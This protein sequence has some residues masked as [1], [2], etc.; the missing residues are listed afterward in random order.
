MDFVL[1]D[2][3]DNVIGNAVS[4]RDTRTDGIPEIVGKIIP[5]VE[6]YRRTGINIQP[7]NTI[8]QLMALRKIIQEMLR[9]AKTMLM[10]PDYFSFCSL[11]LRK[12]NT[13]LCLNNRTFLKVNAD[14]AGRDVNVP[15]WDFELIENLAFHQKYLQKIALPRQYFISTSEKR[16][17]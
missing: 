14:K 7:Y 16:Y 15:E 2:K 9:Q 11:E 1:L 6:L 17:N 3:D 8:Y 5:D 4:Y 10:T 13:Q 12:R